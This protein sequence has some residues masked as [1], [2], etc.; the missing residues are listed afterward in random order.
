MTKPLFYLKI[1]LNIKWKK[2]C[3]L[4]GLTFDY[5]T[6]RKLIL[7]DDFEESKSEEKLQT[8]ALKFFSEINESLPF[9]VDGDLTSGY[10]EDEKYSQ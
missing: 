9:V 5:R 2:I 10:K 1:K 8:S 6:G 7:K 3:L 4:M